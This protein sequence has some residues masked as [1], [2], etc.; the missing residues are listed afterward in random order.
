M[1]SIISHNYTKENKTEKAFWG[2]LEKWYEIYKYLGP[3]KYASFHRSIWF[4]DQINSRGKICCLHSYSF[5]FVF[6]TTAWPKGLC[7]QIKTNWVHIIKKVGR[8]MNVFWFPSDIS[9]EM[10]P[11]YFIMP[12]GRNII[13]SHNEIIV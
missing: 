3:F 5:F 6:Y 8:K 2:T 13:F 7:R 1:T 12:W 11:E 9:P 10:C 4:D